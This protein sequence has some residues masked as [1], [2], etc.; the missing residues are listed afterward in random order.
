M[1]AEEASNLLYDQEVALES[2]LF[3]NIIFNGWGGGW[4][5]EVAVIGGAGAE[6]R[7]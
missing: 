3:S 1:S 6:G 5:L 4:S 7:Q 2:A